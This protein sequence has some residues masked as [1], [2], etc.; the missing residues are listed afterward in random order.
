M[1][2]SGAAQAV[3]LPQTGLELKA[4]LDGAAVQETFAIVNGGIGTMNWTSV[5]DTVSG[6]TWLSVSRDHGSSVVD[7]QAPTVTVAANPAGLS[8]GV[9][10]DR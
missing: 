7:G 6:G 2:V 8:P 5:V 9:Y 10:Y 4:P 1:V 3:L